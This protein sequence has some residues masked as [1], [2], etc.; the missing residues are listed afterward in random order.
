MERA[1]RS[2]QRLHNRKEFLLRNASAVIVHEFR[3]SDSFNIFHDNVGSAVILKVIPYI[4]NHPLFFHFCQ[5]PG[6][7]EIFVHSAGIV[8]SRNTG[9]DIYGISA[10]RIPR[11]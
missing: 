3:E 10:N 1:E 11:T 6:F 2:E 5:Q 7:C 4:Y 9:E 8:L